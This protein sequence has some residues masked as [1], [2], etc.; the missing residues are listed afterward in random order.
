MIKLF[1]LS[2]LLILTITLLNAQNSFDQSRI[3]SR[4]T[5]RIES[6]I[7]SMTL[8]EKI[9]MLVGAGPSSFKGVPRLGIDDVRCSDGPRG[10]H[11][12][13]KN[14]AFSCGVSFGATWN[15]QLI[16]Q[17]SIAMAKE[18]KLTNVGVLLG[19][20]LNILRD[21]LGGRFFE[22]YSE[23]PYLAGKITEKYVTGLQS[24][25]VAVDLKHFACNNREFN[26][27]TYESM[28]DQRTLREIY[29]PAFK[30]GI[31]AGA[32][33]VMTAAN[34][35]NGELMSDNRHL[36]QEILKDEWGFK[37]FV[38]TDWCQTRS[39][40]NAAFAGLDVSMPY[41]ANSK[42]GTPLLEAVQAGKV[43]IS[44][45]DDKVRRILYVYDFIGV[46]DKKPLNENVKNDFNENYTVAKHIAEESI[47]LLKNTNNCLPIDITKTKKI[48]VMG[49]NADQRF[50]LTGLGG[51]SW[52]ES[53]YEITPLQGIINIAGKSRVQFV[54][55]D[56]VSGFKILTANDLANK[57]GFDAVYSNVGKGTDQIKRKEKAV[58][59]VW[60]M[61]SPDPAIETDNFKATFKWSIKAKVSG[62]YAFRI[63]ADDKATLKTVGDGG[64]PMAVAD[65]EKGNTTAI[66]NVQM[67]EGKT[68][69]FEL[70]YIEKTG[71]ATCRL[72]W[73]TP[74]ENEEY[75]AEL[76][77]IDDQIKD[78][79]AVIFVAGIDH[80][81]DSEGR[82]R[83]DMNFPSI[84]EK[85]INHI[86]KVNPNTIVTL[87]NGSPLKLAGWIDN[88]PA[89]LETWYPGMEGGNAIAEILFGKVNPSGRLPFTW[90][91]DLKDIPM[92]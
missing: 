17:A 20:G 29:L 21:P 32:L 63:T 2:L 39:T 47:V 19:P 6:I 3:D 30:A 64:A 65:I 48:V 26:R 28:I 37:G 58:N 12:S 54:P 14:T 7:K 5:P 70:N 51:S 24:Q 52:V 85:L 8:E 11:S 16:E 78:A 45:I 50:C 55:T 9:A 36:L 25:K 46:L 1:V 80:N 74:V 31:D 62:K 81:F 13:R 72:E 44:L 33:T 73:A 53:A 91:K 87:I 23:D 76:Q 66:A 69:S 88:V 49:P 43:P 18:C 35:V 61:R 71:D 68:Y 22:Y 59:F 90:L 41:S 79:D 60:E 34:G 56:K 84:Q 92:Y 77:K 89:V 40:E 75:A 15:P 10:L 83:L 57:D 82:D 4:T 38:L 27:N 67:E 86:S 42:F